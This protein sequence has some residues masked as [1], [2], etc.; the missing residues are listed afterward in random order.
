MPYFIGC[1]TPGSGGIPNPAISY[2]GPQIGQIGPGITSSITINNQ[3][4][5]RIFNQNGVCGGKGEGCTV[6]EFNLGESFMRR[7]YDGT[8]C[9]SSFHPHLGSSVPFFRSGSVVVPS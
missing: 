8:L 2:T 1:D 9:F 5:G 7:G 6:L 3:W 4:N